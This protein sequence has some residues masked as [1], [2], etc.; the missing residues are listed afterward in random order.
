[1]PRKNK[2]PQTP[3][4][5]AASTRVLMDNVRQA[6]VPDDLRRHSLIQA[7]W[8]YTLPMKLWDAL[9][10]GLGRSQLDPELQKIDLHLAA[11][12]DANGGCVGFRDGIPFA[13]SLLRPAP[14]VNP[15]DPTLAGYF[16]SLG[17]TNERIKIFSTQA[18]RRLHVV[19]EPRR[20]YLGW[21]FTHRL[22]LDEFDGLKRNFS[23]IISARQP[24][25]QPIALPNGVEPPSFLQMAETDKDAANSIRQFCERWRLQSIGGPRTIQ[26]LGIQF[27]VI[28]PALS[29]VQSQHSGALLY[30]PDIAPLPDRDELRLMLEDSAR[31]TAAMSDHLREWIDLI[32][33]D[34]QGKKSIQK[35]SRWYVVQHYMR[36]LFSRHGDRL[37]RCGSRVE[38]ALS[39]G[40]EISSDALHR[41]LLAMKKRL[42]LNWFLS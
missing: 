13:D 39:Q 33:A 17:W 22:F 23:E 6:A 5:N 9:L 18:A 41:D 25:P 36:V 7:K 27:P 10:R 38:A 8:F 35:Y 15:Q 24:P 26:P 14:A 2:S 16:R 12:A 42:G 4:L 29:A 3:F 32:S 19:N 11:V 34:T 40:L 21:L 28:L 31:S 30:I 20:G 37:C 1:M